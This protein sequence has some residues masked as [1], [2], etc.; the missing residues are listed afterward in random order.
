M[1]QLFKK[2]MALIIAVTISSLALSTISLASPKKN[3]NNN[4]KSNNDGSIVAAIMALGNEIEALATAGVKAVNNTMYQFDQYLPGTTKANTAKVGKS[5]I[6]QLTRKEANRATQTNITNTLKQ[7]SYAVTPPLEGST[8]AQ[9]LKALNNNNSPTTLTTS[10]KASDSLYTA[11]TNKPYQ[12]ELLGVAKPKVTHDNYFNFDTL[13]SPTSYTLDQLTATKR[14]VQYATQD[15]EPLIEGV[16]FSKLQNQPPSTLKKFVDSSIYKD[17]Q[18][19]IRSALA[20]RSMV[21]SNYNYLIAERTPIAGLGAQA[22]VTD[23]LGK[24]VTNASPLQVQYY[25]ANHKLR[26]KKWYQTMAKA[27]PATIQRET[28]YTLTEIESQNYQAHLDRERLLATFTAM[29]LQTSQMNS[30]MAKTKANK[31]NQLIDQLTGQKDSEKDSNTLINR[32]TINNTL[33]K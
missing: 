30:L 26:S 32:N 14:Y 1:K 4:S 16:D 25:I 24:A 33:N 8:A 28:L 22:G 13:F 31:L 9:Q 17:Y 23:S 11:P 12:A 15:Y 10:T 5:S 18:L 27:S 3:T 29:E 2:K 20:A 6:N 21:L 19:N 7:F